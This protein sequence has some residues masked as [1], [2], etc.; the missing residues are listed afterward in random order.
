MSLNEFLRKNQDHIKQKWFDSIA[1]TYDRDTTRFLLNEKDQFSN[2][3]GFAIKQSVS[4]IIGILTEGIKDEKALRAAVDPIIR[5]R[6]VQD[7]TASEAVSVIFL[8]KPIIKEILS[9]NGKKAELK[10]SEIE[11][12]DSM[13]DKVC[14]AAFDVFMTCREQVYSFKASHVKDRTKKLLEKAGLLAEVPE[15][16][17]EIM[18]HEVYKKNFGN[19]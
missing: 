8:L 6:A 12:L 16:G 13:F 10:D 11:T 17:T 2:P 9:K 14:L 7:H 18:S 19:N 5:I 3:V 1:G 4:D 15:T